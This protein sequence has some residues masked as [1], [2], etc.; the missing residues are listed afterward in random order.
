MFYGRDRELA[1]LEERYNSDR[2]EFLP[3]YGRRRVGKTRLLREFIAKHEGVFFTAKTRSLK[4]NMDEFASKVYGADVSASLTSILDTIEKRSRDRRFV[5]VIDEYPRLLS[6]DRSV[7]DTLQEFIDRIHEDSKLFLIL[8]GSS[9]SVMEHEVL[10]YKSPLYGRRTGSLELLPLSVWESM[11]FLRGFDRDDS[12][13]IYG[14]VG[15]IPMYLS[16]FDQSYSLK[17]NVIRLFL[18][19]DSFFRNEHLMTLI[20]EF[21]NPST[22]YSL[23]GAVASGRSR[24][25]EI[26]DLI[27]LDQP[28]TSK[29]L[30]RLESIGIVSK[31]RPVDNPNGRVTVYRMSDPFLRFQFSRVL[32]VIDDVDPYGYDMLADDILNLF[33]SDMGIVFEG[34]CAEHLRR[35][36]PGRIGTWWGSDPTT[37]R[38]E[39]IDLISTRVIDD[40][41]VGWFAE[42]KYK[43][44]VVGIDVLELLRHRVSLV[45]GYDESK[46]VLYSG[47]GF[48]DS[49]TGVDGV[50]LY[51]LD[52]ILDWTSGRKK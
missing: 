30:M 44:S 38:M 23:I 52:D 28:T 47:S 43:S 40:R 21:E 45:K 7:G 25:N 50:E 32:P 31:E 16:L 34:V 29:Y 12:L 46:L 49:L 19:E 1:L 4:E 9:I 39:E 42:C 26:S 2:F 5:L 48:H 18:R 10:G 20:E 8:C 36:H 35:V 51:T 24:V 3:V 14:M 37:K 6:K 13:R 22:F 41:N 11:E 15:G 33:D 27:G 17:E